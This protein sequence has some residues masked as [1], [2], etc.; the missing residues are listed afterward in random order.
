[1]I[2]SSPS[3]RTHVAV[4]AVTLLVAACGSDDEKSGGSGATDAGLDVQDE[5]TADVEQPDVVDAAE[6][7]AEDVVQD[8]APDG[9]TGGVVLEKYE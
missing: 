5:Q 9:P 2:L 1:M 7:V 8:V 4:F 3:C 6:D